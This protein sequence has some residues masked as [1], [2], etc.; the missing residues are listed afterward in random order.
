[1]KKMKRFL[2]AL[3]SC[4]TAVAC[5]AGISA[6]KKDS[7]KTTETPAEQTPS[8]EIIVKGDEDCKHTYDVVKTVDPTCE[9]DGKSYVAC[10]QCGRNV[11]KEGELNVIAIPKT[12]HKIVE[13]EAKESTCTEEGVYAH[14]A[15][16]NCDKVAEY[17]TKDEYMADYAEI[18]WLLTAETFVDAIDEHKWAESDI[19]PALGM[20]CEY[21]GYSEY[22][23]CET[24][25]ASVVEN[26][27]NYIFVKANLTKEAEKAALN[28]KKAEL[29]TKYE[30]QK[31]TAFPNWETS[32]ADA[33]AAAV[34]KAVEDDLKTEVVKKDIKA[35]VDVAVAEG[36]VDYVLEKDADKVAIFGKEI[37]AKK[38][39]FV[40]FIANI[41][42]VTD[43]DIK[44][45]AVSSDKTYVKAGEYCSDVGFYDFKICLTCKG[46]MDKFKAISV[47]SDAKVWEVY[48]AVK[49]SGLVLQT[50]TDPAKV[51]VNGEIVVGDDVHVVDVDAI[52]A[53]YDATCDTTGKYNISYCEKCDC[54]LAQRTGSDLAAWT[55]VANSF[56]PTIAKL[57]HDYNTD[58][59]TCTTGAYCKR[60]GCDETIAP[61]NHKNGYNTYAKVDATCTQPAYEIK[62]CKDCTY[63]YVV[64]TANANGHD[65]N[66]L[67][68]ADYTAAKRTCEKG[69]LDYEEGN[70]YWMCDDCGWCAIQE[71]GEAIDFAADTVDIWDEDPYDHVD[72]AEICFPDYKAATC[73][74][75]ASG[76]TCEWCSVEMQDFDGEIRID[77]IEITL[78]TIEKES[79]EHTYEN[80]DDKPTCTEKGTCTVCGSV[81]ATEHRTYDHETLTWATTLEKCCDEGDVKSTCTTEGHKLYWTCDECDFAAIG[82]YID[83]DT[84]KLKSATLSIGSGS[85][86]IVF[87]KDNVEKYATVEELEEH[88]WVVKT[89]DEAVLPTCTKA[90]SIN[91]Y[92]CK[93]CGVYELTG[94]LTRPSAEDIAVEALGH[95]AGDDSEWCTY[96]C[97]GHITKWTDENG[98]GVW[99]EGEAIEKWSGNCGVVVKNEDGTLHNPDAEGD[100]LLCDKRD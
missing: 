55:Q 23:Y 28:A 56:D 88:T 42:S 21:D 29:T 75:D 9:V 67:D 41:G 53:G 25:V 36:L 47:D 46:A 13:V 69:V 22:L 94:T 10:T 16:E 93:Y 61:L 6:C 82:G 27:D 78:I 59:I 5:V 3:L 100:C 20:T 60:E 31:K 7:D 62:V 65:L 80:S 90:G 49:A 74:T 52:V 34:K 64:Y 14:L 71:A 30:E 99:D 76:L 89:G 33:Y 91:V 44:N 40:S 84:A 92:S 39:N 72:D 58:V 32:E 2:V 26:D 73:K 98:N 50:N 17:M 86:K 77:G 96:Q 1:M 4:C 45:L 83:E 11:T 68:P 48:E 85:N 63:Q 51:N 38:H 81:D 43:A 87:N 18:K 95:G 97:Q 35:V 79:V 19:Q 12:G 37:D 8:Y 24:C 66:K 54:K 15:C 57:P 70:T